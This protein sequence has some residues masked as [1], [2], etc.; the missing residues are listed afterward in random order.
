MKA[1]AAVLLTAAIAPAGVAVS[2]VM[3]GTVNRPAGR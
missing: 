2:D 1:V 3:I